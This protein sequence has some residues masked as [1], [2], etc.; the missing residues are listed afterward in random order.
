[1]HQHLAN[2]RRGLLLAPAG[3]G[4]TETIARA[5]A[6][7]DGRQLILT[8]THAGVRAIKSRLRALRVPSRRWH[9]E[10][11][12]SFSLRYCLYFPSIS[13]VSNSDPN[14]RQWNALRE[15]TLRALC[16][17]A[18]QRLV[19]ASYAGVFV[20]EYQDCTLDQHRLV[21]ML[22][23]LLPVRIVADPLQGVFAPM[24][25]DFNWHRYVAP[26]FDRL[27]DLDVPWRWKNANPVLGD[28][29]QQIRHVLV[30]GGTI[31][32]RSG[33]VTWLEKNHNNQRSACFGMVK[34]ESDETVVAIM[35]WR[36]SCYEFASKLR[37]TF[38]AMEEMDCSDLRKASARIDAEHGPRRALAAL[39]FASDCLSGLGRGSGANR[40]LSDYEELFIDSPRI[41]ENLKEVSKS[42]DLE[43]VRELLLQVA[44]M[45]TTRLFRREIWVEMRRALDAYLGGGYC[46]L[47]EAASAVRQRTR[48][49]GRPVY[50]RSVS[51]PLLIK[52]LEFDHA[53]VLDADELSTKE[54]YVALTR[55]SKSLT[56][57]SRK[58]E[59]VFY[60]TDI[61]H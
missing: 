53:V 18:L 56:V 46:S 32:W 17:P 16:R 31:D 49:L 44:E 41:R 52:G 47:T 15:S 38:T 30:S 40:Q 14:G 29:L 33:P 9:V 26:Y 20:D 43:A 27:A 42:S 2:A 4:K 37:G 54:L 19:Q 59:K 21:L 3:C 60:S 34:S 45:S 50:R 58:P 12:D 24:G 23:N 6:V 55:G 5:V 25:A 10:T 61:Y 57:I 35:K 11:I 36:K 51:T 22:T 13:G 1:M 8:H 48:V 28:W 39:E 7:T